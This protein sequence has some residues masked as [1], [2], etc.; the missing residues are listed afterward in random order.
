MKNMGLYKFPLPSDCGYTICLDESLSINCYTSSFEARRRL[1]F[2]E[3]IPTKQYMMVES[4][5]C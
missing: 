3:N 4:V 1:P 5:L 2:Y